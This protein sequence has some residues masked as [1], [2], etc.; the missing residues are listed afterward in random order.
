MAI[1]RAKFDPVYV[2][3]RREALFILGL[4]LACFA[5]A[6][7]FSWW[8][9]YRTE[10]TLSE[11]MPLVLGLPRWVF[12]GIF[13]PWLAVDAITIWFALWYMRDDDLGESQEEPHT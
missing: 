13:V 6:I 5:W 9:G 4:F 10:A 12:W 2:Q 11:P 8:D 7:L 1:D 3:A